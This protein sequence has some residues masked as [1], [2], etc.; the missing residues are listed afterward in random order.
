[1]YWGVPVR[2]A[3]RYGVVECATKSSSL[4]SWQMGKVLDDW[5]WPVIRGHVER[6]SSAYFFPA[7]YWTLSV[8]R[9][10]LVHI[11]LIRA[12]WNWDHIKHKVNYLLISQ[13]W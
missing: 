10:F 4:A 1:M 7:S 11:S 8:E 2:G 6:I 5:S 3:F 12:D 13:Y 9:C